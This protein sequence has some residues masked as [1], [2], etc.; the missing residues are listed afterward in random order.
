MSMKMVCNR[1]NKVKEDGEHFN[2]IQYIRSD[3]HYEDSEYDLCPE[4]SKLFSIFL[5]GGEVEED[6]Y[7]DSKPC[8]VVIHK[9]ASGHYGIENVPNEKKNHCGTCLY[10]WNTTK[11]PRAKETP[12]TI[13]CEND[14]EACDEWTPVSVECGLDGA[15]MFGSMNITIPNPKASESIDKGAAMDKEESDLSV[16]MTKS[17]SGVYMPDGKPWSNK[18][19]RE[20]QLCEDCY[21]E[22]RDMNDPPCHDC[23]NI[24]KSGSSSKFVPKDVQNLTG[25]D[26]DNAG[27]PL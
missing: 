15:K 10:Q 2:R 3:N 5:D 14:A 23:S 4:C 7:K 20:E 25:N 11:C 27:A 13:S 12:G 22:H 21:F 18:K 6:R 19:K 16:T 8:A 26:F 24:W 9:L 1:C 17:S